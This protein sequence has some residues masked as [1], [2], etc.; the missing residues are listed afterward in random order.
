MSGLNLEVCLV[1]L[2]DIIVLSADVPSHLVR[3]RAV[4]SR[5]REAGLKLKP[6]KCKLLRRR[7]G[8]LSHIV[9]EEGIET[10]S[11]KIESVVTWPVLTTVRNVRGFLGLCSYYH[12]FVKVFVEVVAPFHAL[13]EKYVRFQWNDECQVAFDRLNRR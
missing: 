2:D 12:R 5:L 13:T 3:L 1:Y 10:D 7:V 11:A 9:S 8:F 4:F 6:S